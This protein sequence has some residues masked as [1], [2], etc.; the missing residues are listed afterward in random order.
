LQRCGLEDVGAGLAQSGLDRLSPAA[1]A[2]L[3]EIGGDRRRDERR[4]HAGEESRQGNPKGVRKGTQ[5]RRDAG[6]NAD[7]GGG[8]RVGDD[9]RIV[10]EET[11]GD[12]RRGAGQGAGE[13][14]GESADE[15]RSDRVEIEGPLEDVADELADGHVEGNADDDQHDGR[16]RWQAFRHGAGARLDHGFPWS[17]H[18]RIGPRHAATDCR[19][20]APAGELAAGPESGP[21]IVRRGPRRMRPKEQKGAGA[22][23]C[24]PAVEP[25]RR[26]L[27]TPS[28]LTSAGR[29]AAGYGGN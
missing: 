23:S 22:T 10:E 11:P 7:A 19:P 18:R 6:G 4:H 17:A 5:R 14:P 27:P 9:V 1:A 29:V 25:A 2:P 16:G 3:Q 15:D 20:A 12:V 13:R 8:D 26:G 21:I 28:T 24:D